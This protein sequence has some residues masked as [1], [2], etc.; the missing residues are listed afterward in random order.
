MKR[1]TRKKEKQQD[2]VARQYIGNLGKTENGIVSVNAYA[3]VEGLTYPL[4]F[5]V[6]KPKTC[7]HR[8]DEYKNQTTTGSRNP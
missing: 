6:F 1:E 3:V 5:K 2:Y 8:S 7:L 4:L